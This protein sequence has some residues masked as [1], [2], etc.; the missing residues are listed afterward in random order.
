MTVERMVQ[1]GIEVAEYLCAHLKREKVLLVGHS[2]GSALGALMALRRPD[3]FSAYVGTGLSVS[4]LRS[5]HHS[6][7]HY[8]ARAEK[9]GNAEA[10]AVLRDLGPPPYPGSDEAIRL[11]EWCEKL[12]VC[13]GDPV[14]PRPRPKSPEFTADDTEMMMQGFEFSR[15]QIYAELSTLD[16]N[17]HG[18]RYGIP[19]YVFQ[20]TQDPRAP[21]ELAE[22]YFGRIEAPHKEFVR[23]EGCHHFVPM[24]CP[25]DFL[26]ELLARVRPRI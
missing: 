25:Q 21:L 6:Y 23:F 17:D 8:L 1:D 26:R 9:A 5:Q 16:L 14:Y 11:F 12:A 2:W 4:V 3:L 19:V 22:D 7:R 18:F 20:G 13:D 24:N 10:L 15:H